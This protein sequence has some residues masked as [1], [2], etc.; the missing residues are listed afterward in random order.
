MMGEPQA[1]VYFPGPFHTPRRRRLP[2]SDEI[3]P[4]VC[5]IHKWLYLVLLPPIL[6]SFRLTA[7]Y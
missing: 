4:S 7:Y 5:E 2:P 6:T 3:I 1:S